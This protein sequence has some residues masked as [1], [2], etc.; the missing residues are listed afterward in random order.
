MRRMR[1]LSEEDLLE[2]ENELWDREDDT[3][4]RWISEGVRIYRRLSL[5]NPREITYK[6]TLAYLI[7]KQGEDMKLR[8]H[9]YDEAIQRF[10]AVLRI[11]RSN[12]RAYYR[13]GFLYFGQEDWAKSIDS[14]QQALTTEAVHVRNRLLKDQKIKAHHYILKATQILANETLE[15][16]EKIPKEELEVFAEIKTLIE[17]IRGGQ[18]NFEKEKPYQMIVNGREFV[19]I[20]EEEYVKHSDPFYNKNSIILNQANPHYTTVSYNARENRI[21]TNQVPLLEYIMRNPDGVNKEDII[22]RRFHG[23]QNPEAALRQNIRRLR[24]RLQELDPLY[25]FIKTVDGGYCWNSEKSYKMIKH[26]RD[27]RTDMLLD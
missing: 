13:L 12:S 8:Q 23:S 20:T 2:M 10:N 22:Q 11:D 24:S 21:P 25:D 26:S 19:E 27:I 15:K 1:D 3:D 18:R 5:I 4:L 16:I 6:E 17:D 9:A 14:F 7:L